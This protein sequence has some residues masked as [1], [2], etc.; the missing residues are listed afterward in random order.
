ML[1][2]VDLGVQHTRP[3]LVEPGIECAR[4]IGTHGIVGA[5]GDIDPDSLVDCFIPAAALSRTRPHSTLD[6]IGFGF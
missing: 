2:Q 5:P 4:P 3:G 1:L 6:H